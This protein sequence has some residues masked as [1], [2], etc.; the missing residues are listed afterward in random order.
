MAATQNAPADARARATAMGTLGSVCVATNPCLD[1]EA[2]ERRRLR[3]KTGN[4]Q[5]ASATSQM[6][7][8]PGAAAGPQEAPWQVLRGPTTGC[9]QTRSQGRRVSHCTAAAPAAPRHFRRRVAARDAMRSARRR[10]RGAARPRDDEVGRAEVPAADALH[11]QPGLG[12]RSW[13]VCGNAAQ[14]PC[15]HT[16]A[17]LIT[18]RARL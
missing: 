3:L 10:Q 2:V 7:V 6:R 4:L 15:R 9:W 14:R 5:T 17:A 13:A 11:L 18:P 12:C 1:R 16:P 8:G